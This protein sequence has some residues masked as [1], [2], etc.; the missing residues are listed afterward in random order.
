MGIQ[1]M[2]FKPNIHF[3]SLIGINSIRGQKPENP[4]VCSFQFPLIVMLTFL[5]SILKFFI[6]VM[7]QFSLFY[8]EFDGDEPIV[9][10]IKCK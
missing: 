2:P 7:I 9:K 10:N 8:S 1:Q 4:L 3:V 5:P 6:S